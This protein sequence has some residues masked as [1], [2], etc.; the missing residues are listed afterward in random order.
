MAPPYRVAQFDVIFGKG[1]QTFGEVVDLAVQFDIIEKSGSW[2]AYGGTRL[3]Q[4][5]D[6]AA[7]YLKD[8][9]DLMAEIKGKVRGK[10]S[11]EVD[12]SATVTE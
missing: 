9:P 7:A 8:H 2:Y 4:G 3:A 12:P 5:R 10:L 11:P 1:I 6:N